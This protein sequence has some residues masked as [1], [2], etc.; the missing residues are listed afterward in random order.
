MVLNL[1]LLTIYN[2]I[3][4]IVGYIYGVKLLIAVG[5]LFIGSSNG[6]NV[7]GVYWI[8]FSLVAA[9]IFLPVLLSLNYFTLRLL[10]RRFLSKSVL[11]LTF[12]KS[13]LISVA[14][15]LILSIAYFFILK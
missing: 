3:L 8:I 10:F 13:Y 12:H 6:V 1:L 11:N 14:P 2:S 7:G 4:L 5:E 15:A 9:L